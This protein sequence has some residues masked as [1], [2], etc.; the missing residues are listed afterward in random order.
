M[1]SKVIS[2]DE[3]DVQMW[4]VLNGNYARKMKGLKEKH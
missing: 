2:T 4:C 1:F 3:V